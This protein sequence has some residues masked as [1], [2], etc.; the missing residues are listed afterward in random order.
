MADSAEEEWTHAFFDENNIVQTMQC[1]L[2]NTHCRVEDVCTLCSAAHGCQLQMAFSLDGLMPF[3]T[4]PSFIM[5]F[6]RMSQAQ[7]QSLR[8]H[9]K[10]LSVGENAIVHEF[11]LDVFVLKP[12]TSQHKIDDALL[13]FAAACILLGGLSQCSVLPQGMAYTRLRPETLEFHV[14]AIIFRI[15]HACRMKQDSE[16]AAARLLH[17]H[18]V[19]A[20]HTA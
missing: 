1:M 16:R 2:V 11:Y 10:H 5:P 4:Y 3:V 13:L 14:N 19:L 15:V 20:E 7:L 17:K 18:K 9:C 6:A 12:S 8:R